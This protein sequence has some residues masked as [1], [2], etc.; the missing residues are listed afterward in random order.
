LK[1]KDIVFE[2]AFN[3][4]F[5]EEISKINDKKEIKE[6]CKILIDNNIII[7]SPLYDHDLK[8]L[9]KL[10]NDNTELKLIFLYKFFS[11]VKYDSYIP[12]EKNIGTALI[13]VG[14]DHN[15]ALTANQFV[16]SVYGAGYNIL[17]IGDR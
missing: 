13:L 12:N 8:S 14:P 1:E 9:L 10:T 17:Y 15:G 16:A 2:P 11:E 3:I 5:I 4:F 7:N 6:I